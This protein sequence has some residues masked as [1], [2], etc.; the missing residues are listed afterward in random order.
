MTPPGGRAVPESRR[1]EPDERTVG[2]LLLE[3]DLAVRELLWDAPPDVAKARARTWGEVVEAAAELWA[4]IPDRTGDRSMERIHKLTDGMYRAQ[5]RTGWPG[6]GD[7]D[8]QLER[9]AEC[10][11]RAAEMVSAR[12]HPTARLSEAAHLDSVAARTRI[13]HTVYVA[14]H[15]VGTALRWYAI[16]M[17]RV[18]DGK[19]R[20]AQGQSADQSENMLTRVGT[21]ERLAGTYL[22]GRWPAG[23]AGQHRE[24]VEPQ[25]LA[26]AVAT[27][28]V[29]SRRTLTG[30]PT[31]ADL[32][33]TV[34]TERDLVLSGGRVLQAAA[35]RRAIDGEQHAVRLR[36]ALAELD[37]SWGRVAG[38]LA[39]LTGL[40]RR[41]AP[42]LL[43]AGTELRAALREITSDLGGVAAPAAM[44][45]RADLAA[46]S[47]EVGRGLTGTVDLGHVVREV[48]NDPRLSAPAKGV[49]SVASRLDVDPGDAAWVEAGALLHNRPVPLPAAVRDAMSTELEHVTRAAV[50]ADSAASFL[51]TARHTPPAAPPLQ[52]GRAHE[53]R[54]VSAM[55][56]APGFGCDR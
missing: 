43:A 49:Q 47:L 32:L 21:A 17:R 36:P 35:D 4:A 22:D 34:R 16:D 55:T 7:G 45:Q 54:A 8:P 30:S 46:A 2:D 19:G 27:W 15:G 13:M 1:W 52:P 24:L 53:S 6:V 23:L 18:L 39:D 48:V 51:G 44:A 28:A 11:S 29:Q 25:R 33:Y 12:R 31:V 26:Q 37:D 9:A 40:Q 20:V 38:D 50:T 5:Q 41:V 14:S 10:L 3:A 42:D 56:A